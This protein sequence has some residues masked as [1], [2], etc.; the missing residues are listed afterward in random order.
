MRALLTE[1]ARRI[2]RA[3]IFKGSYRPVTKDAL[4]HCIDLCA[5]GFLTEDDNSPGVYRATNEGEEALLKFDS[6]PARKRA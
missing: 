4:D 6:I 5:E 3:A 1:M 2:L